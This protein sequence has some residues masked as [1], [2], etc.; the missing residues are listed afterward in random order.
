MHTGDRYFASVVKCCRP[1]PAPQPLYDMDR[2][3]AGYGQFVRAHA[4]E[5]SLKWGLWSQAVELSLDAIRPAWWIRSRN[6]WFAARIMFKGDLR[7]AVI[8]C[9]VADNLHDVNETE[10]TRRCGV[11]RR[12][13]H[14]ALE[15][16]ELAGLIKRTIIGRQYAISLIEQIDLPMAV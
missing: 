2:S 12:A 16:L 13:M 15:N 6:P 7:A 4:S 1:Y 5:L 9:L 11:T 3:R 8:A 10:L 14:L